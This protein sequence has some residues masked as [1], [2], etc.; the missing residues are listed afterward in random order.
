VTRRD[1]IAAHTALRLGLPF[2]APPFSVISPDLIYPALPVTVFAFTN[3]FGISLAAP[4][5]YCCRPCENHVVFAQFLLDEK[6]P[7]N[8]YDYS[9]GVSGHF[10]TPLFRATDTAK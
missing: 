5:S 6:G 2:G 3:L 7:S 1:G 10:D 9:M 8:Q 4:S